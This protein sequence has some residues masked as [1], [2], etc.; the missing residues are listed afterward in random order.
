MIIEMSVTSER[1]KA[2]VLSRL[3]EQ[4]YLAESGSVMLAYPFSVRIDDVDASRQ[5]EVLRLVEQID[6]GAGQ[7]LA[8]LPGA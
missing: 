5:A 3:G 1:A 6:P 7:I 2:R 8:P 4:G